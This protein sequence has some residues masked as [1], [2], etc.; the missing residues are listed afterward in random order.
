MIASSTTPSGTTSKPGTALQ[1]GKVGQRKLAAIDRRLVALIEER[2]D[3]DLAQLRE[4]IVD[5][6]LVADIRQDQRATRHAQEEYNARQ[7]SGIEELRS[8]PFFD[9]AEKGTDPSSPRCDKPR[10]IGRIANASPAPLLAKR[11]HE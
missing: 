7:H 3:R 1:F 5:D 9:F 11:A 4:R 10:N 8:V 6:R 2:R